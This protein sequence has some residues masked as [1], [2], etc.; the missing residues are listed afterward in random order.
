MN[1]TATIRFWTP[2]RVKRISWTVLFS[3]TI[4]HL[5][6]LRSDTFSTSSVKRGDFPAFYSGAVI[7]SS[8]TPEKLYDERL[9]STIQNRHWPS[10]N[11]T[12][13]PFAYPP[14]WA[15]ILSPL[16]NFSPGV[17]KLIYTVVMFLCLILTSSLCTH[18]IESVKKNPFTFF[19][20]LLS[21]GPILSG[22]AA[23]Q[24]VT[25]SML[26]YSGGILFLLKNTKQG[27][28]SAGVLFGLWFF[29]P[30]FALLTLFFLLLSRCYRP[31]LGAL[32]PCTVFYLLSANIFG[33]SWPTTWLEAAK[34]FSSRDL[35]NNQFQMVSI[36][37]AGSALES[38]LST[39]GF[40]ST[41]VP[42]SALLLWL[43]IFLLTSLRFYKV[44]R[45][46][47]L[48][49]R[50]KAFEDALYLLGPALVLLSPHALYYDFGLCAISIARY[51]KLKNDK[52]ISILLGGLVIM[53][54][55]TLSREEFLVQP[56]FLFAFFG[57]FF[58]YR[59][60]SKPDSA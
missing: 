45:I 18:L 17:A 15:I 30:H 11:N 44:S 9:Q 4:S 34:S 47:P 54:L 49:E 59:Q 57:Y 8:D 58:V 39:H 60:H 26:L 41:I 46:S 2:Q 27:E 48:Q 33:A 28:L 21:F 19:V 52:E 22:L 35:S 20:L 12:Y 38:I 13:L 5:I 50:Q 55:L 16:S 56:M 1:Q 7:I 10:L 14:F 40:S 42:V 3:L 43:I 6:V 31:I 32:L 23:S 36:R 51:L 25:L 29:K 53:F 37:G 24:N